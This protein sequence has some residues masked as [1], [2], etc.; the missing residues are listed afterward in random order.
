VSSHLIVPFLQATGHWSRLFSIDG[1]RRLITGDRD[2]LEGY[3]KAQRLS[4]LTL[5]YLLVDDER[6]RSRLYERSL[7]DSAIQAL[8]DENA[9]RVIRRLTEKRIAT[10]L[11]KGPVIAGMYPR[12][13]LRPYVDLDLFVSRNDVAK[14]VETLREMGLR[15]E[16]TMRLGRNVIDGY[17]ELQFVNSQRT[18]VVDLQWHLVRSRSLRAGMRFD[19]GDLTR[20]IQVFGLG[21]TEVSTF[22]PEMHLLYLISHHMLHHR[23]ERAVWLLDVLVVLE[24]HPAFDWHGLVGLAREIGLERPAFYHLNALDRLGLRHPPSG[25]LRALRPRGLRYHLLSSLC[26]PQSIFWTS[27]RRLALRRRALRESLK[28]PRARGDRPG[29]GSDSNPALAMLGPAEL[30]GKLADHVVNE[31]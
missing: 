18:F 7:K 3:L 24:R 28:V 6:L 30:S 14:A 1:E 27:T 26:P 31:P 19:V 12:T 21:R 2:R 29:G 4:A 9:E 15:L 10:V 16:G 13:S 17:A 5:E 23:F 8:V 22:R 11:V 20:H 25:V